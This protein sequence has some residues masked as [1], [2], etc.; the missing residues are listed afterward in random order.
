MTSGILLT[1]FVVVETGLLALDVV[2]LRRRRRAPG[3]G[4]FAFSAFAFLVLVT[5]VFFA[6]QWTGSCLVPSQAELFGRTREWIAGLSHQPLAESPLSGWPLLVVATVVFYVAGLCDYATHRLFSHSRWFW[7]THEYHHLPKEINVLMP[8]ILTRP[9]GFVPVA[10]AGA[11]TAGVLYLGLWAAGLPLWDM[12]PILPALLLIVVVLTASHSAFLRRYPAVHWVM[13]IPFFTTPQEH[14]LHH[15]CAMDVNFG[16]FTTL[17]DR[18]LGTYRDP[19][20]NPLGDEPLGL[21]YDQDFLGTLT[22]GRIK[23][24]AAVRKRFQVDRCCNLISASGEAEAK[25]RRD[26]RDGDE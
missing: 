11:A 26:P 19:L 20:R 3:A 4:P 2:D 9:F 6:I 21:P 14:I 23:L 22:F 12:T 25:V 24:P 8:G 7:F 17:W 13:R 18:L 1:V 16:N 5:S 15:T 10:L